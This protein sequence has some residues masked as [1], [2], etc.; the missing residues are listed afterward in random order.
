MAKKF[1]VLADSL[2]FKGKSVWDGVFAQIFEEQASGGS[3][4]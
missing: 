4:W 1:L 2:F 3:P